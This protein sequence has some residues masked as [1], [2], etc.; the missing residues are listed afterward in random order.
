MK[1][2]R[3]RMKGQSEALGKVEGYELRPQM[4]DLADKACFDKT[5]PTRS[6]HNEGQG[7]G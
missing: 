5:N 4:S 6:K 3:A 1:R 2:I 7:Y